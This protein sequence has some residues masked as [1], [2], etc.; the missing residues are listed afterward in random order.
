MN[1]GI[2]ISKKSRSAAWMVE[3]LCGDPE[4]QSRNS[5]RCT[6]HRQIT[7]SEVEWQG[8]DAYCPHHLLLLSI[9][10]KAFSVRTTLCALCLLLLTITT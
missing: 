6:D 7:T 10:A 4:S 9:M 5:Y 3:T 1:W 8:T 2:R